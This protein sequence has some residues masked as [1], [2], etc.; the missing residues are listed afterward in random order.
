MSQDIILACAGCGARNRVRV[1]RLAHAAN[2]GK[3]KHVLV[4]PGH[5]LELDDTT[6]DAVIAGSQRGVLVDFW[7]E[8]C[9]PCKAFAPVLE[10]FAKRHAIDIL[11]A[12]VNVDAA[13]AVAAKHQ[14]SSIPTLCIFRGGQ[15]VVRRVG[16]MS[17]PELEQMVRAAG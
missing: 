5:P 16:G 6:L 13:Q 17:L 15:E 11:V 4:M 12:K 8:W 1:E 9:G 2:C 3:C 10:R 14:V 7:A